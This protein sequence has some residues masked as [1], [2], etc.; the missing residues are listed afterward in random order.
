MTIAKEISSIL[1]P[2]PSDATAENPFFL[3]SARELL[4]G[5][6]DYSYYKDFRPSEIES[7][8]RSKSPR[9]IIN[10]IMNDGDERAKRYVKPFAVM[11]DLT[12]GSVFINLL[13]YLESGK[14]VKYSI[15]Q[16]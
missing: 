11:S 9:D 5:I 13:C 12:L 8:I 2:K 16:V 4:A 3:T 6:I 15:F 7:M 10:I 14:S 1:C